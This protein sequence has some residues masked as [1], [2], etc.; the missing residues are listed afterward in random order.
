MMRW[1]AKSTAHS[2]Q[3][4]GLFARQSSAFK[5]WQLQCEFGE[6]VL[7]GSIVAQW[8]NHDPPRAHREIVGSW[9]LLA[10]TSMEVKP[11]I[12]QS[13]GINPGFHVHAANQAL[14][15]LRNRDWPDL[16]GGYRRK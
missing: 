11:V 6:R 7:I 14:A 16:V 4:T 2:V 9:A 13:A 10:V 1:L 3:A 8:R 12:G 5:F 15:L